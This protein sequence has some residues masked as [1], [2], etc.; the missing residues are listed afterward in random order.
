MTYPVLLSISNYVVLAFLTIAVY[1]LLPL[2]FA[3]PIEFGGLGFQPPAIGFIMGSYGAFTGL[4]QMF[5]FAKIIRRFG[6]RTVFIS[7]V[8]FFLPIFAMLPVMSIYARYHGVTAFIGIF[9]AVILI[10]MSLRDMAF[11]TYTNRDS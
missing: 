8:S 10:L 7:S 9:I 6:E 3:M 4:F 11:G 1:A 2:F 5:F